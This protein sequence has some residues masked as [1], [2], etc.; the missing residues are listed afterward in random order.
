MSIA[1][2]LEPTMVLRN[3][4]RK[5]AWIYVTRERGHE[6]ANPGRDRPPRSALDV[7][8]AVG[9]RTRPARLPRIAAP[10]GKLLVEHAFRSPAA[11]PSCRFDREEQRWRARTDYSWVTPSGI[12]STPM[13][14]VRALDSRTSRRSHRSDRSH[15]LTAVFRSPVAPIGGA[16]RLGIQSRTHSSPSTESFAQ[17]ASHPLQHVPDTRVEGIVMNHV[18]PRRGRPQHSRSL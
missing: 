4:K 1:S 14:L 2:K 8:R 17:N 6:R 3:E 13:G 15:R 18:R 7:A 16:G 10:H 11:T 9:T 5:Q 12:T